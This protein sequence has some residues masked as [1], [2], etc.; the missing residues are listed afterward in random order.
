MFEGPDAVKLPN[1]NFDIQTHVASCSLQALDTSS[2][3]PTV[4]ISKSNP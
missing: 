3:F 1:P 2:R 4:H